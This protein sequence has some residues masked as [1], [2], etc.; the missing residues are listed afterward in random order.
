[1]GFSERDD[2]QNAY[3]WGRGDW[4][5]YKHILENGKYLFE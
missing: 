4:D 2:Q 3:L 1:M 5:I